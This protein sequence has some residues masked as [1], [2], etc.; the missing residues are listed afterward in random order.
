MIDFIP[1]RFYYDFFI[2]GALIL[3][4]FTLLHTFYLKGGETIVIAYNHLLGFFSF[5][6][7]FLYIGLRPLS[8]YYFIDMATYAHIFKQYEAGAPLDPDGDW[9]FNFFTYISA[10]SVSLRTYFIFCALLYI[11]PLFIACLRWFKHY[12]FFVFFMLICS[13][14]FYAYGVNGMR[15]GIATS[16]FVLG[17]SYDKNQLGKWGFLLFAALFH[18]SMM[19]PAVCYITASIYNNPKAYLIGWGGS[20]VLSLVM[21]SFWIGLFSSLGFDDD[22]ASAYLTQAQDSGKFSSVGFR[23]DFLFYSAIPIA[24]GYYYI[25]KLKF[26]D[27]IYNKIFGTY[28]LANSFWVLVIQANFSNRFAYLSWFL[29]A[30][31]IFY[32]LFKKD[33]WTDQ[34]KK[35]GIIMFGYFAITYILTVILA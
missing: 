22:R 32:P 3:L 35:A 25:F 23:W 29:M 30:L 20:I 21:G 14:S 6:L 8:E 7:V 24:L 26:Q 18:K 27:L 11:A 1:L 2:N 5:A 28:L 15:N 19:L 33:I 16:F 17:L 12:Y 10:N 9:A 31:V 34:F 4:L 13:Y